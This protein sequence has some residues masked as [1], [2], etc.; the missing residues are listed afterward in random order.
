MP[1]K[2]GFVLFQAAQRG[3]AVQGDPDS[4]AHRRG[5]GVLQELEDH[6]EETFEKTLR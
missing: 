3:Q 2:T 6:K 5:R 1:E 4:H